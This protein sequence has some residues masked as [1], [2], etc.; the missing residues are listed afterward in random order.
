MSDFD[1]EAA[2]TVHWL[3]HNIGPREAAA[4]LRPA[5]GNGE[6]LAEA[7]L[8]ELETNWKEERSAFGILLAILSEWH[9]LTGFD[10]EDVEWPADHARKVWYLSEITGG[11]FVVEDVEQT[12][13]PNDHVRLTLTHRGNRYSFTF[14][15]DGTWIN[16]PGLLN[17]L[18]QVLERLGIPERFIELYL[19]GEGPG[20]VT[21]VLPDVFLPAARELHI[22]LEST[23]DV[24]YD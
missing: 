24:K 14:Q 11:R 5:C 9:R 17:G 12:I 21:C 6:P 20:L 15:H 19:S 8:E 18:N 16:L 2:M 7:K 23:P 1:F 22:R 3:G 10:C 13:E 4:K